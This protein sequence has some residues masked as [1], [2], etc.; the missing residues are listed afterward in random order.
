MITAGRLY[1]HPRRLKEVLNAAEHSKVEIFAVKLGKMTNE[2]E[3][4][5]LTRNDRNIFGIRHKS[6]FRKEGAAILTSICFKGWQ[7]MYL[8]ND[9]HLLDDWRSKI[10]EED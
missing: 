3:L 7:V 6:D 2:A 10:I 5:G 1:I 8:L 4:M 9:Q